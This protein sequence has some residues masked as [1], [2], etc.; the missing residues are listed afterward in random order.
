MPLPKLQPIPLRPAPLPGHGDKPFGVD[1]LQTTKRDDKE[2]LSPEE[3]QEAKRL[4]A[5][6]RR[7]RRFR[8]NAVIWSLCFIILFIVF[9]FMAR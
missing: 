6:G 5:E 4:S 9:Y 2:K 8:R 1:S 3:E 7:R